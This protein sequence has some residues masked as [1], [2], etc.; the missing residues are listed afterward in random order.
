MR[1]MEASEV[2]LRDVTNKTSVEGRNL[3]L[4]GRPQRSRLCLSGIQSDQILYTARLKSL[5][6]RVCLP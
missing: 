5:R 3:D 1:N 2:I 6:K 4:G